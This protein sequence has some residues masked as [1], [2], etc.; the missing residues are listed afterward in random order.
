MLSEEELRKV[1]SVRS[2]RGGGQG[3]AQHGKG[4]PRRPE[5]ALI[6]STTKMSTNA[7]LC[8]PVLLGMSQFFMVVK[9]K[10]DTCI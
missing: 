10:T 9:G 7:H 1:L 5:V 8:S 3:R 6:L 4:D 2:Q